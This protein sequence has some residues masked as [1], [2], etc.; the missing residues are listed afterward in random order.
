MVRYTERENK[1]RFYV[2]PLD[3][4]IQQPKQQMYPRAADREQSKAQ[5]VPA[6]SIDYYRTGLF[7]KSLAFSIQKAKISAKVSSLLR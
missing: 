7:E 1:L 6:H 4:H 2:L 3:G 5:K